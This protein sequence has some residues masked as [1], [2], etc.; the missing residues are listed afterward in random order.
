MIY[1]ILLLC[2][3]IASSFLFSYRFVCN[4]YLADGIQ[5][6]DECG[7]CNE[8]TAARWQNPN[9]YL[10]VD[11]KNIPLFLTKNDWDLVVEEA[12]ASWNN[13][14]DSRFRFIRLDS[15]PMRFFGVN[16]KL[17][18]I[19]WVTDEEEW[20]EQVGAGAFGT[21]GATMPRYRCPDENNPNRVIFD[22]DLIL[23]G[24]NYINWSLECLPD[25]DCVSVIAT[26]TH[27]LGHIV[28]LDHPCVECTNSIMSARSG[29]GLT[30]PA[31]DDILGIQALYPMSYSSSGYFGD[32]CTDKEDCVSE[33][34]CIHDK[35]ENFCSNPCEQ[36]L[37]CEENAFCNK[38]IGYCSLV[39]SEEIPKSK[40]HEDCSIYECAKPLV[41]AGSKENGYYCFM[42]C[43]NE[44]QCPINNSCVTLKD[45]KK[46]CLKISALNER[47]N[48]ISIC[49]DNLV[50]SK[51]YYEN[52][53]VCKT[54][55]NY[56]LCP[57]NQV[58]SLVYNDYICLD[59]EDIAQEKQHNFYEKNDILAC[60]SLNKNNN[61]QIILILLIFY[62]I[63]KKSFKKLFS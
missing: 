26:L 11:S 61:Y 15:E 33:M 60:N 20:K 31:K 36:D 25:E 37:D 44:A 6:D 30:A 27:E 52:V 2:I 55:C 28:G 14:S 42:P 5:R 45:D 58:C 41:C 34:K 21:L 17:H 46:I 19:F 35:K 7:I 53:G 62:W 32:N 38:N 9:V 59:K 63:R 49:N 51:A 50:C 13:I 54:A 22:A 39:T 47:C 56:N 24:L 8:K 57:S 16:D 29:N 3:N 40:L 10:T 23:N 4:G 43:K 48:N 12:F 1:P 18:E